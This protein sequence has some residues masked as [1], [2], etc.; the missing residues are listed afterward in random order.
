MYNYPSYPISLSE[1]LIHDWLP[2]SS[3]L[4]FFLDL[5]DHYLFVT[6]TAC[7]AWTFSVIIIFI[8]FGLANWDCFAD[9]IIAIIDRHILNC[10]Y[11]EDNHILFR[12]VLLV[13]TLLCF[14]V[15]AFSSYSK[16]VMLSLN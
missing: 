1:L 12:L 7:L 16:L 11:V 8:A 4:L 3:G 5:L 10:L 9:A 15:Y 2:S 13:H 14:I 6:L